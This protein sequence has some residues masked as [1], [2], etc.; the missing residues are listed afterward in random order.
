MSD[1]VPTN[2]ANIITYLRQ[3]PDAVLAHLFNETPA[4]IKLVDQNGE[5]VYINDKGKRA[6]EIDPEVDLI[7]TKWLSLLPDN[8]HPPLSTALERARAGELIRMETLCPTAKGNPR[9]WDVSLM[10]IPDADGGVPHVVTVSRDI[11][12]HIERAAQLTLRHE[13]AQAEAKQ[14]SQALNHQGMQLREID[15]RIKNS[16]A[17]I[18]A[19]LRMQIRTTENADA[20][21]VLEDAANRILTV[22]E[23]HGQ[24]YRA[25]G[26]TQLEL[27]EYLG[28]LAKNIVDAMAVPGITLIQNMDTM[29]EDAETALALGL[30]MTELISNAL[31][32]AFTPEH[33]G[34]ITLRLI[35]TIEGGTQLTVC[36]TGCGLEDGFNFETQTNLGSK[37][38]QLYAAKIGA[39]IHAANAENGGAHFT[40]TYSPK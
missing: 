25:P 34:T 29:T 10:A 24:L 21:A 16:L 23:V 5:L 8:L 2:D 27:A 31:R 32:H 36:D 35:Q 20:R 15:H 22:G 28:S 3:L 19:V 17:M 12:A 37:I 39:A 6:L 4:C 38:I 9:W 1:T 33:T 18:S 14:L 26:H 7:G 40:V 30:V 11:T 13:Q